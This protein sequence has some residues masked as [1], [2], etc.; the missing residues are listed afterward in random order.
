MP[1]SDMS[2][3]CFHEMDTLKETAL[4]FF[5]FNDYS[6]AI[7]KQRNLVTYYQDIYIYITTF[8]FF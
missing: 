8:T 6:W 4:G 3:D 5:L 1:S 7:K 2:K